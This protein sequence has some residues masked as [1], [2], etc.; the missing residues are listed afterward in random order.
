MTQTTDTIKRHIGMG[1]HDSDLGEILKIA[2]DRLYEIRQ[3][4]SVDDFGVGDTI[5]FNPLSEPTYLRGRHAKVVGR[6]RTKLLVQFDSPTGGF[7]RHEDGEWKSI[8][9]RVSPYEVDPVI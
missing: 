3:S 9:F 4:R 5:E 8:A 1:M 7:V 2:G 6:G